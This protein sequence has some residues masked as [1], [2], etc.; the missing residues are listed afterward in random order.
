MCLI[1]QNKNTTTYTVELRY[2]KYHGYVEVI[3]SPQHLKFKYFTL[4]IS[5]T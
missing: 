2:L 5:N 3:I 4:D 1:K